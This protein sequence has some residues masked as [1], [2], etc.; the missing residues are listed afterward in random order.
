[1]EAFAASFEGVEAEVE[2]RAK[3]GYPRVVDEGYRPYSLP[4][5]QPAEEG[6][7]A[8]R[9]STRSRHIARV[10]VPSTVSPPDGRPLC[11]PRLVFRLTEAWTYRLRS[12]WS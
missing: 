6:D 8:G 7:G 9:F 5:L 2:P 4:K 11:Q 10:T 12:G 3:W 1:L